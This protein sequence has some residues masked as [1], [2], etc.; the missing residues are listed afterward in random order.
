VTRLAYWA[1]VNYGQFFQFTLVAKILGLLFSIEQT[2]I[3]SKSGWARL[4][5]IISQ[6][7]LV[8]LLATGQIRSATSDGR[9]IESRQGKCRALV[10]KLFGQ[11]NSIR[12]NVT[13]I[14]NPKLD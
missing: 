10:Q 4:W 8:T 1:F 3:S 2:I 5:A 9:E 13:S 14:E 12:K 6:T 7:H 11:K